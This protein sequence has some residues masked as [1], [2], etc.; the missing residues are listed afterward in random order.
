MN[1]QKITLETLYTPWT[2]DTYQTFTFDQSDE[3]EIEFYNDEN[4]TSYDYDD[5]DWTYDCKG[6]VQALA[7]NL[8]DKLRENIIDDVIL[9]IDSDLKVYTPKEYNFTTDKIFLDFTVNYDLLKA[10]VAANNEEYQK[11]KIKSCSGFMWF[12]E[13]E[14]DMLNWYLRNVSELIHYSDENYMWDQI[15]DIYPS[16]YVKMKL[17]PK[18]ERD[19]R[20]AYRNK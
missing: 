12:G 18:S 4:N 9:S 16:E 7:E 13:E 2:L 11:E 5:F 8:L 10:Y 17:L 14:H 3:N 20:D 1:K 19:A 15:E 6:Y